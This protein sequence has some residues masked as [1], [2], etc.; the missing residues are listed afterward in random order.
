M[1]ANKPNPSLVNSTSA[2]N[3]HSDTSKETRPMSPTEK[4]PG[5]GPR[6][7]IPHDRKQAVDVFLQLLNATYEKDYGDF[8]RRVGLYID[9]LGVDLKG[10]P[11]E[12][13]FELLKIKERLTYTADAD[14]E[15]SR[16]QL[17]R[18]VSNL[19]NKV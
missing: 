4:G 12:V 17:H 13:F 3:V 11:S 2:A 6:P 19:R 1:S 7:V 18:E 14:I 15:Q 5:G 9:R 10:A 8:K 16:S